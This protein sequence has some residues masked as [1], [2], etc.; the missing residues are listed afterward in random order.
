MKRVPIATPAPP[1][2]RAATSL[3]PSEMAPETSTGTSTASLTYEAKAIV[4]I[5]TA[6]ACPT[7]SYPEAMMA[8]TPLSAAFRAWWRTLTLWMCTSQHRA[9]DVF[10]RPDGWLTL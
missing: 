5:G 4:C 2:A 9:G 6:Y 7:I 1:I 10:T 3:R 8:F